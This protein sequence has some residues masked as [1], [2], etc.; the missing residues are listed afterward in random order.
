MKLVF[1]SDSFKGSLS[2]AE[3]C[4]LLEAEAHRAFP[5]A[6]C[7]PLHI[8]DGGEG[9]LDAIEGA[10]RITAAKHHTQTPPLKRISLPAH[11]ALMRVKPCDILIGTD[12]A[13]VEV[14]STCGL[15]LLSPN[16]RNPLHTT[17]YGVGEQLALA[18]D[19]DCTR[20]TIGLGGSSTNDGGMGCLRA[21]GVRF[22][23]TK[24]CELEGSG[25]DLEKVAHIDASGIHPRV[26]NA[27]FTLMSDVT[28]PL[29]GEQG[30]TQ[31]FGPQKGAGAG[32]L[33]RLEAG[34]RNLS[35]VIAAQRP[36]VD[37]STPGFGAAGGL[38]M[39]L[40]VFLK[41]NMRSG[42]RELLRWVD[43]DR[44]I[45]GANL[46]VTGEGSLDEQSLQG[47]AVGVIAEHA[48]EA[49]VP[50]AVICGRCTL[51]TARLHELGIVQL[52]EIGA[53]Q[54]LEDA[55]QHAHENYL[56]AARQLFATL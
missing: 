48:R 8:A 21:L 45:E 34:M 19:R 16:E 10:R 36:Q 29:L 44:L 25:A 51:D 28:N 27:T 54:T 22:Y 24:G 5:Q 30:A 52:Y 33:A 23:D 20:I 12:E 39:A 18:L 3:I 11:D 47:K 2:S 40:S 6:E 13:F 9:T 32:D 37:F 53:G 31:V 17:S 7:L 49:G 55:L 41:A 35:Q 14:A 38:G 42:I 56:R 46:I 43:F 1:A 50:V 26:R 15:A 4:E